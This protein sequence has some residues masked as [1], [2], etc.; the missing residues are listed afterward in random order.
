MRRAWLRVACCGLVAAG[1][2]I[3]ALEDCHLVV[4]FAS[5]SSIG[6]FVSGEA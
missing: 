4:V 6:H 2:W 5:K 1:P 3:V